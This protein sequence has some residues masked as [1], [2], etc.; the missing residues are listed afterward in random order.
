MGDPVLNVNGADIRVNAPAEESLLSV[1]RNRLN[2]TG[3]KYDSTR[4]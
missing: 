4:E 3:T 2:L 1:L